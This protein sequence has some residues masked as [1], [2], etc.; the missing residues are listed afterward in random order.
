[1]EKKEGNTAR[2]VDKG[3]KKGPIK[4]NFGVSRGD[5]THPFVLQRRLGKVY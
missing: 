3:W 2:L 1:M 4:R 5:K